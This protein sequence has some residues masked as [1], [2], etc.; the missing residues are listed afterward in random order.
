VLDGIVALPLQRE[1]LG[2]VLARRRPTSNIF[3]VESFIDDWWRQRARWGRSGGVPG[4]TVTD[5]SFSRIMGVAAALVLL[6]ASD[7]SCSTG[8]ALGPDGIRVTGVV[9]YL[10]VEGGCWQLRTDSGERYELRPGQ[11]PSTILVDGARVTLTL[12]LRSDLVSVCMVGRIADVAAV[13]S[14]RLP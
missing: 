5:R 7:F 14:V 3:G 10:D 1:G 11:A 12:D 2:R 9:L 4:S 13:E 8:S 6:Q